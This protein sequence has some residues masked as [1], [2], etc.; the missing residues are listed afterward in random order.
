MVF[1][2]ASERH[3]LSPDGIVSGPFAAGIPATRVIG[4][5]KYW[6]VE[7]A[8]T[9]TSL[10]SNDALAAYIFSSVTRIVS[11]IIDPI[12]KTNAC[13]I[14]TNNVTEWQR[15]YLPGLSFTA[16]SFWV[17]KQSD[18][19]NYA[20]CSLFDGSQNDIISINLTTGVIAAT[21][22][23]LSSFYYYNAQQMPNGW[24]LV[25]L[26]WKYS[27]ILVEIGP[28]HSGSTYVCIGD[29]INGIY[30]GFVQ[31]SSFVGFCGSPIVVPSTSPVTRAKD[32]GQFSAATITAAHQ[33]RKRH[34]ITVYPNYA[35]TQLSAGALKYLE[36]F[37]D[38]TQDI[39]IYLKGDGKIY[40]DGAA[41]LVTTGVHTWLAKQALTIDI[42]PAN[43]KIITSGFT[44]GN[45]TT[46][47]TAWSTDDG[48]VYWGQNTSES[49]QFD[50]LISEPYRVY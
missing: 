21:F 36:H 44:T 33:L 5:R 15:A 34:K 7:S 40:V 38:A 49:N 13:L 18:S 50:G 35:S 19:Y 26:W 6:Q 25:S 42:D 9:N 11:G 20:L 23:A 22:G 2:N 46:T 14:R 47:G 12:T 29:G 24:W 16:C 28:C 17:K 1:A 39:D 8:E 45:G 37:N 31:T 4:G 3:L 10:R 32:E 30:C 41:N 48:D 43:G 27:S